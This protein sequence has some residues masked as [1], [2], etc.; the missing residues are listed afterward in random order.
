ME[1]KRDRVRIEIENVLREPEVERDGYEVIYVHG[2][3]GKVWRHELVD[4]EG[5]DYNEVLEIAID[6]ANTGCEVQIL[7]VLPEGHPLRKVV[8]ADAKE[9]KCPDLRI[10]GKYAEVKLP[11]GIL[12]LQK[13]SRNIK[14]AHTQADYVIIKLHSGFNTVSLKSIAKGRFLTHQSLLIIEFKMNSVYYSFKR[15]DFL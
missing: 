14:I 15:G 12:Q 2:S 8:F 7:P 10:N 13:I 5:I 3:G 1:Q 4:V 11:T 6:K 9:R